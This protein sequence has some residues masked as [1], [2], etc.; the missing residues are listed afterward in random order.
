M[1]QEDKTSKMFI[2]ADFST[3]TEDSISDLGEK[4]QCNVS[5]NR[6]E[7]IIPLWL[8]HKKLLLMT[9]DGF[10]FKDRT[11]MLFNKDDQIDLLAFIDTDTL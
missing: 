5:W 10:W 2:H 8:V 9:K 4:Y 6:L 1:Y 3:Q 7:W 11:F